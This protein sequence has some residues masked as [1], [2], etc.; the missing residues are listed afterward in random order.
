MRQVLIGVVLT[1]IVVVFAM[2][3]GALVYVLFLRDN[4]SP[5]SL[6]DLEG[7]VPDPGVHLGEDLFTSRSIALPED[8]GSVTDFIH[9][10]LDD[11]PDFEI[12]V[13][14]AE[15]ILI[16]DERF[17]E[18][19]YGTIVEY[20]TRIR[21]VRESADGGYAVYNT[22][23]WGEDDPVAL[24]GL[25]GK[26]RWKHR[27]RG[28]ESVMAAGDLDGDGTPEF[29]V[30]DSRS[31]YQ[32]STFT[33]L[34]AAGEKLWQ[35]DVPSVWG[36]GIG[37]TDG[38]G[39]NE[40]VT[41]DD[42]D[43][44]VIRSDQGDVLSEQQTDAYIL[45]FELVAWPGS[46]GVENLVIEEE[47]AF[48]VVNRNG[49]TVHS[50][51]AP[52]L[53]YTDFI[54]ATAVVLDADAAPYLAVMTGDSYEDFAQLY[55]YDGLGMLVYYEV[56]D[57]YGCAVYAYRPKGS[58]VDHLLVGGWDRILEY[59]LSERPAGPQALEQAP[60]EEPAITPAPEEAAAMEAL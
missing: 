33:L 58:T 6:A 40:I 20:V 50:L 27:S 15:G 44:I 28:N 11:S 38:D 31:D 10:N 1:L 5:F 41:A 48:R 9:A 2:M 56:F 30:A 37:D 35:E 4:L 52:D 17:L 55:V 46:S 23:S 3:G 8:L 36:L 47:N 12:G 42:D 59:T 13:A 21:F 19:D 57:E 14:S 54:S 26:Q 25:D 34:G 24:F 49:S 53:Y 32:W 29:C 22:E 18:K 16:L 7:N 51:D 45:A 43:H 60:P 39:T